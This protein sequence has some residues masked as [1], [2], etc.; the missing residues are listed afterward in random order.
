MRGGCCS[1]K[2][3]VRIHITNAPFSRFLFSTWLPGEQ[4]DLRTRAH[5]AKLSEGAGI[6]EYSLRVMRTGQEFEEGSPFHAQGVAA[7]LLRE[8]WLN[9]LAT[10]TR[11]GVSPPLPSWI[12]H[13]VFRK[14]GS[15]AS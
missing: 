13:P 2:I 5:A 9:R 15:S 12:R 6:P 3:Q 8:P 4:A 11:P 1:E 14:Y 7:I 10:P